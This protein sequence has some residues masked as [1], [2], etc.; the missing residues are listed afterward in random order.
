ME[1]LEN[2]TSWSAYFAGVGG[3]LLIEIDFGTE[4]VFRI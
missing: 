1:L 3:R 4:S 2:D